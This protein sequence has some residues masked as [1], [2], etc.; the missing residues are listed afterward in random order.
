MRVVV[1]YDAIDP[2]SRLADTLGPEERHAFARAMRQDVIEALLAIG[3]EPEILATAAIESTADDAVTTTIDDR[4]L[5]PA[6]NAVLAEADEPVAIIMADLALATQAT[7]E[8]LFETPGD[9][10]IVPGRGGGTNAFITRDPAFRVDYHGMSY[11]DHR[12]IAREHDMTVTEID[13]YRL[14]TDID[15]RADL[16]EVL[17]HGNG[18]SRR[19]LQDAGFTIAIDDGRVG[20]KRDR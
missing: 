18:H 12:R 9:L 8:R 2:K 6:V 5:T 17:L 14:A 16:V 19:W 4:P 10:A 1:P 11:L 15:E 7:L 13:S 20:I 3:Y